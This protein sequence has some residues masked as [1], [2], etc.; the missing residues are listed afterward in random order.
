[1][2][3]LTP[4]G[5]RTHRDECHTDPPRTLA[6]VGRRSIGWFRSPRTARWRSSRRPG[7]VASYPTV[8]AAFYACSPL[9]GGRARDRGRHGHV[10]RPTARGRSTPST[11][12]PR[13]LPRAPASSP[14]PAAAAGRSATTV[15]RSDRGGRSR[16]MS[17]DATRLLRL[18]RDDNLDLGERV[19]APRAVASS[20]SR[21]TPRFLGRVFDGGAMPDKTGRVFL[22]N[23]LSA[24]GPEE[25]GEEMGAASSRLVNVPS[26]ASFTSFS[27]VFP[28]F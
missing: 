6:A 16:T 9:S 12:A 18:R 11:W 25:L 19:R 22:L 28:V 24:D 26:V 17:L 10:H 1:M 27:P 23:P 8:P 7:V 13:S 2:A 20:L 21:G 5:R 4:S 3:R 14:T 15:D